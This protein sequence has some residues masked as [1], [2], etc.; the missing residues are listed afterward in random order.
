ML[1]PEERERFWSKVKVT[2]SCWLWCAGKNGDGYG[3]F[4]YKGRPM[5]AHIVSFEDEY[6]CSVPSG[7]CV[8][9]TCDNPPCIRPDHLWIGTRL[10]NWNDMRLKGRH[11]HGESHAKAILNT[12]DIIDIRRLRSD[13]ISAVAIAKWYG[14]PGVT[15]S[16]ILRGEAWKHVL[17]AADMSISTANKGSKVPSAKL[18]EDDIH[19]I[20][21]LIAHNRSVTAI[22]TMFGVSRAAIRLIRQRRTWKHVIPE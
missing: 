9:H 19:V 7:L 15:V 1:T 10:D 16:P 4:W 17:G 13:G 14:I 18:H 6:G 8:C 22:A 5:G 2:E 3:S 21:N 11:T 12:Q 20:R